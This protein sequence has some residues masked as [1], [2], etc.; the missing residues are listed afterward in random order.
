MTCSLTGILRAGGQP[1][2]C[3]EPLGPSAALAP[4]PGH[5]LPFLWES[6]DLNALHIQPAWEGSL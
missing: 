3:I 2:F 5:A 6:W 1:G 4:S